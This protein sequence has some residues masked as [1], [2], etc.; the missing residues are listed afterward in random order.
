MLFA[1]SCTD[2][3]DSLDLRLENRP[4]HIE[5]LKANGGAIQVAGPYT[6]EDGEGMTG[7]LLIVEAADLAAAQALVYG[8][9]AGLICATLFAALAIRIEAGHR[10]VYGVAGLGVALFA[11]LARY[12]IAY[13]PS[14][15]TES[16]PVA[17]GDLLFGEYALALYMVTAL[18]LA[19]VIA[20]SVLIRSPQTAEGQ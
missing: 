4:A 13:R 6:G 10:G 8:G 2:K 16:L 14:G 5:F 11:L 15:E 12:L 3:P 20:I 1:I 7:S 9:T 19:A 18:L 17:P